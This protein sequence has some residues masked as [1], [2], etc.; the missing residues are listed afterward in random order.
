MTVVVWC[1]WDN[2]QLDTVTSEKGIALYAKK[3]IVANKHNA[4]RKA[5]DQP[6]GKAKVF[7]SEKRLT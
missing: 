6:M 2:L 7:P 1:D 5:V 4:A 3:N